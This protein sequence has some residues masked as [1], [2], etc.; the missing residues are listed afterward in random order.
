MRQ[1]DTDGYKNSPAN[2][3][4]DSATNSSE[5]SKLRQSAESNGLLFLWSGTRLI[6]C[7]SPQGLEKTEIECGLFHLSR[8]GTPEYAGCSREPSRM[9]LFS[10]QTPS[11]SFLGPQCMILELAIC[12]T[13]E[14]YLADGCSWYSGLPNGDKAECSQYKQLL[15]VLRGTVS[16][17]E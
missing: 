10:R 4:P 14:H 1:P 15:V 13:L 7:A 17:I 2:L 8:L 5:L 9:H 16:S 12:T 11:T 6:S 3:S